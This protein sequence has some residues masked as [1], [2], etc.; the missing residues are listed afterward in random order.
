MGGKD[1]AWLPYL[2]LWA[3]LLA[4]GVAGAAAFATLGFGALWI[5]A[6]ATA[7][8]GALTLR[9]STQGWP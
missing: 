7:L 1:R 6:G 9:I 3:G 4:G 2:L 8:L 5:A